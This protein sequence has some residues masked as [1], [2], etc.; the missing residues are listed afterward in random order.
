MKKILLFFLVFI[1][2]S[3]LFSQPVAKIFAFEQENMPGTKPAGVIDENGKAVKK[4]A[5]KKKYFIFLSYKKTYNVTPV[6]IFIRGLAF[7]IQTITSRKTPVEYTNKT[8]I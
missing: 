7:S 3:N 4:A 8:V 1:V 6:Q 2:G 5:A